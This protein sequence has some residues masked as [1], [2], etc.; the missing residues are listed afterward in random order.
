MTTADLDVVLALELEAFGEEAWS[1]PDAGGRAGPAAGQ[2]VLPGRRGRRRH[3]DRRLRRAAGRR[4][5]GRR[6]H[7]RGEPR[8]GS[9][10][11][12]GIGP[13][14]GAAGRGPPPR[15]HRGLPGGPGGQPQRPAALHARAAS[16][17]SASGAATTSRPAPTPWSCGWTWPRPGRRPALAARAARDDRAADP[18]HRDLL[19]RDRRRAGPR[20]RAAGRRGRLQRR[21][22][23][24]GSA[25]SC[26]RWPAGRTWRPW[27]RP[28]TGRWPRPG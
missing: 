21:A 7:H 23:T 1:R 22:S 10:H 27:S 17:R 16:S 24:R 5:P 11:G 15:L 12:T 4:H 20:A 8:S 6:G 28:S 25:A 14:G 26:P 18:R 2:P 9:G 3:G 13:A 19:R